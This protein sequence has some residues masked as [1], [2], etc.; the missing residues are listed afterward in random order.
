MHYIV[1]IV[2]RAFS[3]F[4]IQEVVKL[5]RLKEDLNVLELFHGPTLA[6]KDLALSCVGQLL[7]YVLSKRKKHITVI[8][9]TINRTPIVTFFL[10]ASY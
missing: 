3:K 4:D 10:S 5:A 9:G 6:F 8:V 7:D 2:D 1:E